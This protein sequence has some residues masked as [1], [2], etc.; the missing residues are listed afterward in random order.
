MQVQQLI[1]DDLNKSSAKHANKSTLVA[2]GA[3]T[4]LDPSCVSAPLATN[5]D[6]WNPIVL[7]YSSIAEITFTR[8]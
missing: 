8:I 6:V 2:R 4:Q 3:V 1:G 7:S 5:V